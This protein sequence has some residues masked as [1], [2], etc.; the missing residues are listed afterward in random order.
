MKKI[1]AKTAKIIIEK[2][3]SGKSCTIGGSFSTTYEFKNGKIYS[4]WEDQREGG[5]G[6]K[7]ISEQKLYEEIENVLREGKNNE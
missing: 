1:D 2:I 3:K 4:S 7:E 5:S 6:S